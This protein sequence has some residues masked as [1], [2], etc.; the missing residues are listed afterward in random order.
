MYVNCR[1]YRNVRSIPRYLSV[2]ERYCRQDRQ[3]VFMKAFVEKA[4]QKG[5]RKMLPLSWIFL[6]DYNR[7][8]V[9]NISNDLFA[10]TSVC[11]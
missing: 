1:K 11:I 6:K 8:L 9:T 10:R 3:K 2:G 5:G 4:Q 7:I